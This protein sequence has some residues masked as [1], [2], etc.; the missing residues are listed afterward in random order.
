MRPIF[1]LV[2]AAATALACLLP[3]AAFDIQVIK[4]PGGIEAWLVEEHGLP[5]ISVQAGFDGGTRLDPPGKSGL[6]YLTST[7][8]NEGAGDLD[9]TAF[10][11]KL[12]D[13]A[14]SFG[15]SADLDS[16]QLGLTTLT[17]NKA[18]A[19]LWHELAS[20]ATREQLAAALTARFAIDETTAARDVDRFLADLSARDL[21]EE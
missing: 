7:L 14:I 17:A 12:Q 6:A 20:G 8:M 4:S 13:K 16:F 15:G 19:V 9:S 2:A 10:Q 3:A 5:I 18:G 11:Q 1:R 21:I